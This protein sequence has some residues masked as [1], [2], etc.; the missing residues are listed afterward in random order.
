MSQTPE[1]NP[2]GVPLGDIWNEVPLFR[3]IQRVLLSSS[4]PVNWEL[5]RQIGIAAASWGA[6]DPSPNAEDQRGFEE[7]VRVAELQ[8]AGFTE[9]EPPGDLPRVEAVRRSQWVE[10]NLQGLRA[11][12]EPAA[13][14]IGE[15]VAAAQAESMP[16]GS[17]PQAMTQLLGQLSPLLLGAQV[18]TVL[19]SLG[20]RVLGQYDIAIPRPD[21]AGELLFV[22]PNVAAFEKDWSLDPKEF[23]TW[24][25][26]HEVTHRFEFARPWA[27]ARF[28]E[29][30][31]DYTST[32]RLDVDELRRRLETLDPANPDAMQQMLGPGEGLF[33]AVLD[34]EQRLKLGRIQAFMSAAEGYGDHVVHALGGRLLSSAGRVEE[35]VSRIDTP[36]QDPVFMRLLGVEVERQHFDAGRTFCDKVADLTDE[37]TLARMWDSADAMPSWPE[38]EEPRLWLARTV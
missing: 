21:G 37:A 8:V 19:G 5:A 18:G 15:A 17:S 20:Q 36:E 4:G 11:V 25:A 14:K 33:G 10:R 1:E 29:L 28:R 16:E 30:L 35:A 22:V 6:D 23:R 26:I 31:D 38:V 3:E 9:L 12:V 34:D 32:L 27:P 2:F 7:A 13:G 24:V